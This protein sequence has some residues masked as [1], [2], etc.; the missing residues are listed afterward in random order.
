[1]PLP[2]YIDDWHDYFLTIAKAAMRKSK[3]PKCQVGAVIVTEGDAV[4]IAIGFNGF[5]RGVPDDI[6]LLNDPKE[7]LSW[8]CHAESNA[9]QNAARVGIALRGATMYTTKFP[10][11]A[12]CNA[13]IQAG[14]T[15]IYTDDSKYWDDDPF[16]QPSDRFQLHDRKRLLL[17]SASIEILAPRHPEYT[18]DHRLLKSV[19]RKDVA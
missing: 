10:C 19:E 8:V 18:Q 14:I 5:A 16:D 4:P 15:T 17:R 9:I 6:D 2:E 3:D 11:L 7:K 13:I 12:C 1:M